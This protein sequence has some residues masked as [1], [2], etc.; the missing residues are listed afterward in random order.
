[1]TLHSKY[2]GDLTFQN[3]FFL[4]GLPPQCTP[5]CLAPL[6]CGRVTYIGGCGGGDT[7]T[8]MEGESVAQSARS[9]F[10]KSPLYTIW[11]ISHTKVFIHIYPI[12]YVILCYISHVKSLYIYILYFMLYFPCKSLYTHISYTLCYI[13]LYF[14]CKVFIHIC[15]ILHVIFPMYNL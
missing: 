1:M 15:A 13:M 14:P 10:L 12:L 9:C 7:G 8:Y 4:P 3:V 6:V 2:T 5:I 11:Y